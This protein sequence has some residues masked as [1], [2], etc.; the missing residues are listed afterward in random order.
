MRI[1]ASEL[2]FPEGPV[3]LSDGGLLLVEMGRGCVTRLDSSGRSR[4][5]VAATGR[6]NGLAVDRYGTIWVAEIEQRAVLRMTQDGSYDVFASSCDG[7]PFLYPNDLAFSPDGDLYLTDS[8]ILLEELLPAG[9]LDPNFRELDYDGR[10]YRI[11]VES[12]A[13]ELVDRGLEFANGLAFGP[14]RAL[15]VSESLSG[16]VY[17]YRASGGHASERRELFGN[18]LARFEPAQPN[19][20]DGMKFGADGNLYVAVFGQGDVTVLGQSGEVLER[21]EVD[22]AMPTNLSFGA[23]GERRMYVTEAETGT[24]QVLDVGTSGLALYG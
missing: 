11:D 1:F 2:D 13:A 19:G 22:G 3:L 24:V 4:S 10:V 6:P 23:P 16:N 15:Y 21:L 14:D 5:I 8:G 17:R 12:G 20:P 18:V 9:E 7:E